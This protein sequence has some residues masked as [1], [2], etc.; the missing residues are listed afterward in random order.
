MKYR[1]NKESIEPYEWMSK[2]NNNNNKIESI[3]W[4][5]FIHLNEHALFVVVVFVAIM[6]KIIIVNQ[7]SINVDDDDNFLFF[8]FRSMNDLLSLLLWMNGVFAVV[9]VVV[10]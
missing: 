10:E 3:D 7:E 6:I 5:I 2:N 8:F 4:S 9:V 1:I